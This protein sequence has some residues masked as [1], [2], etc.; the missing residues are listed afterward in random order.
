M[1]TVSISICVFNTRRVL[2]ACWTHHRTCAFL[3]HN[4]LYTDRDNS[5]VSAASYNQH[6]YRNL[7]NYNRLIKPSTVHTR[8]SYEKNNYCVGYLQQVS[9]Q[10]SSC[11]GI[12]L[13]TRHRRYVFIVRNA[14]V[15]HKYHVVIFVFLNHR[16]FIYYTDDWKKV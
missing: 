15:S 14:S 11:S 8:V 2:V 13:Y 3:Y 6:L 9:G 7:Y 4:I 10:C 16:H 12:Q 1:W 5:I